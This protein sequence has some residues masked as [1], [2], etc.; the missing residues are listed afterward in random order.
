VVHLIR[1]DHMASDPAVRDLRRF[2]AARL[3]PALDRARRA[4]RRFGIRFHIEDVPPCLQ[5]QLEA[6]DLQRLAARAA[7]THHRFE[8]AAHSFDLHTGELAPAVG[9]CA[10]CLL[11]DACRRLAPELAG[12]GSAY[13]AIT[14]ESLAAA[15]EDGLASLDPRDPSAADDLAARRAALIALDPFAAHEA[16]QPLIARLDE[17]LDDLLLVALRERNPRVLSAAALVRLGIGA[18]GE[19]IVPTSNWG[20]VVKRSAELLAADATASGTRAIRIGDRIDIAIAGAPAPNGSFAARR[21]A[22]IRPAA[23]VAASPR[24]KALVRAWSVVATALFRSCDETAIV[25]VRAD[26]VII[27]RAGARRMELATRDG[28]SIGIRWDPG[29]GAFRVGESR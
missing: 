18:Q 6:A 12:D 7:V 11:R 14:P 15:L 16:L 1:F 27:E 23:P 21:L 5:P 28:G 17:A 4:A 24:A 2:D 26:R 19:P 8:G 3:P 29:V 20:D 10:N 25:S 22:W 9:E 13:R